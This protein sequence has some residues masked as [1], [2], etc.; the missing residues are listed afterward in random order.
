MIYI[1]SFVNI[2]NTLSYHNKWWL[3]LLLHQKNISFFIIAQ[4]NI[5]SVWYVL[6][7][8]VVDRQS[9]WDRV[10]WL[11]LYCLISTFNFNLSYEI[12]TIVGE[13]EQILGLCSEQAVS[14]RDNHRST[15]AVTF[16]LGFLRSRTTNHPI[17]SAC[18]TS[19]R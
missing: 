9:I 15:P 6:V 10:D 11:N 14:M 3:V 5:H 7:A 4:D 2:T 19:K 13:G 1:T 17:Q 8:L 18:I 12:V 16:S